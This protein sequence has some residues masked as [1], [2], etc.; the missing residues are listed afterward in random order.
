[1]DKEFGNDFITLIDEDGNEVE[2]ELVDSVEH[3][4]NLYTAF[5]EADADVTKPVELTILKVVLQ[6]DEEMLVSLDDEEEYSAMYK[7]F[8]QRMEEMEDEDDEDD[9]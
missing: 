2:F 8:E 7:I 4:D 1:M 3:D 5:I 6:D 9:E